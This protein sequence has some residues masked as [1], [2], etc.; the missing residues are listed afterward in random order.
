MN[1]GNDHC[2]HCNKL[3]RFW[4]WQLGHRYQVRFSTNIMSGGSQTERK[5][6]AEMIVLINW[7]AMI[8]LLVKRGGG[9]IWQSISGKPNVQ[10]NFFWKPLGVIIHHRK[11]LYEPSSVLQLANLSMSKITWYACEE[12]N[13][14]FYLQRWNPPQN[15]GTLQS[16]A[17]YCNCALHLCIAFDCPKNWFPLE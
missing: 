6:L 4:F 8:V 13:C 7:F 12:K 2:V 11:A 1:W 17:L 14:F 5:P 9:E 3:S 15:H 10:T 16:F